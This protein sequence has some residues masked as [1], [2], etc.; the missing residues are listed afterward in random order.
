MMISARSNTLIIMIL[1]AAATR[2][3]PHPPNFTPLGAIAMFGGAYFASRRAAFAVPLLAMFL[4]N[5]ALGLMKYGYK[6]VPLLPWVYGSFI[7]II[8]LGLLL[9]G[10]K[11]P[12]KVATAALSSSVLFFVITNFGVW[13]GSTRYPQ[14][15]EGLLA[16][17]V[18]ALPYFQ[19][20][21]LG[22]AV[23]TTVLF[24]GFALAQRYC[25]SLREPDAP[26]T[27]QQPAL[28]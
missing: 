28:A 13:L 23:Y 21:L 6:V 15:P 8:C 7:L 2:L 5:A 20:T 19:N 22:D 11:S 26:T 17:Y 12:A 24:G 10:R 27:F 18:A 25:S 4:S 1:C 16:C 9:R 3:I 14:T